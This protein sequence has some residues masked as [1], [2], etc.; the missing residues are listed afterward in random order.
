VLPAQHPHPI[1]ATAHYENKIKNYSLAGD[2]MQNHAQEAHS[3]AT[4]DLLSV[5]EASL[6]LGI[7]AHQVHLMAN[8]GIVKVHKT[9]EHGVVSRRFFRPEDLETPEV[10]AAVEKIL[11]TKV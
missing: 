6:R 1:L 11:E 9:Q 5:R 4:P 7:T 3:A 8:D 10:K 2:N